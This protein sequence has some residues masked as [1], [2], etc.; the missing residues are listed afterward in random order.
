LTTARAVVS[1]RAAGRYLT[2]ALLL[3]PALA[4]LAWL[5]IYPA[6]NAVHLS[7]TNWDGFTA[8]QWIGLENFTELPRDDRFKEAVLH[9]LLIVASMPVWIGVPYAIALALH[10]EVWG[11]R[12]LRF[13]FFLPVVLSPVVV[14]VYYGIVLQPDGPLNSALES[15]GLDFLA[16]EWLNDPALTLP[17]VISIIIWSTFG[18]GVLIFLSGLASLDNEQIDAARV[19]GASSWQVQRHVIFWQLLPMI[20]FWA[21]L[22]VIA[23]FTAF[24]PLIYTL[25][26]GGPGYA[27]YTVDFDLYQEAF[28]SGRLGYAS[29]IGVALLLMIAAIASATLGL[30]RSRRR[31]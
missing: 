2:P 23:S 24:F 27:T 30:L 11:W 16:R 31:S 15:I 22:I 28:T 6:G 14:G 4:L 29:A 18:I 17:V 1:R 12:F 7:L 10:R 5:M 20:E 26:H 8:P 19:D 25:T 21:V 13:A 3:L 9:N